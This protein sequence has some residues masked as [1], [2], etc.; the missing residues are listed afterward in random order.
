MDTIFTSGDPDE[1]VDKI[2]IDDLY[3]KKKNHDLS[4]LNYYK[5]ILNRI[6]TKIKRIS[7]NQLNEQFCWFL[8][9]EVMIGVPRY[10]VAACTAYSIN[11]LTDN[12]FK[13]RYTHPNLLLISWQHWIPN[14]VREEFKKKQEYK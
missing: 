9:P 4:N 3:D 2:S 13:V 1:Y 8:I 14:Y 5:T 6:H 11:K 7:R 12:G 10:D